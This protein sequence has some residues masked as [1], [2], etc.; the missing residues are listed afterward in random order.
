MELAASF[1]QRFNRELNREPPLRGFSP[2]A[3]T[4]MVSYGWPGNVRELENA[5]ERAA[6]LSES[7][8]VTV[9]SLPEKL[10]GDSGGA[11]SSKPAD[12]VGDLSLKRAMHQLE[13]SYIRAAL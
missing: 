4:M 9:D 13:E 3:E 10:W 6:L 5:M 11:K 8:L 1:L 12:P 7:E 2:G